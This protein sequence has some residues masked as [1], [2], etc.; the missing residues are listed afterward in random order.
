MLGKVETVTVDIDRSV[1]GS[2]SGDDADQYS[3]PFALDGE[4]D[5]VQIE[6]PTITSS[7]VSLYKHSQKAD[8][9]DGQAEVPVPV[10]MVKSDNT[11]AIWARTAGTA[12]GV[13]VVKTGGIQYGRIRC[14]TNQGADRSF[15]VRG[16][17]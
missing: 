16:V 11:S 10:E 5:E 9:G 12:A 7:T 14:N 2:F 4:Y 1:T 17:R 6:C 8:D 13:I 3:T 15:K